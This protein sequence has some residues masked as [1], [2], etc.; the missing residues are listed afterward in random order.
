MC[1]GIFAVVKEE[2]DVII[3]E[4]ISETGKEAGM[5]FFTKAPDRKIVKNAL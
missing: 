3:G 1:T 2:H 5:T 4:V